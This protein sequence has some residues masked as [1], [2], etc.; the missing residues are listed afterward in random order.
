MGINLRKYFSRFGRTHHFISRVLETNIPV[1]YGQHLFYRD[2]IHSIKKAK[3]DEQEKNPR[4][5][6]NYEL[7]NKNI[8]KG[9]LAAKDKTSLH[10]INNNT[11]LVKVIN[12]S[13]YHALADD[14][15]E[16]IFALTF[17][18]DAEVIL[19]ISNVVDILN[20]PHMNFFEYFL[21][22]LVEEK[23]KYQLIDS[24]KYDVMYINNFAIV[25]FPF[26]SGGRLDLLDSFMARKG[27]E[28]SEPFRKLFISRKFQG[29]KPDME[30]AKNFSYHNDTRID[31]HDVLEKIFTDLGFEV[32]DTELLTDFNDQIK[33]FKE[34]KIVVS[35]TSSGIT[36]AIF[37]NNGST[38]VE[39]V[40]PLI[41]QS[42]LT[43]SSYFDEIGVDPKD[44]DMDLNLVQEVH[45]FYHNLAFFKEHLYVSIP[46]YTREAEKIKEFI[47]SH[48]SLK[49]LLSD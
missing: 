14:L 7:H 15:A 48:P 27:S 41:T 20:E 49:A 9:Y 2:G 47:E 8:V 24:S 17:Y 12:A 32:V 36:N 13:F 21:D 22:R 1:G 3:T 28:V 38:L 4:K 30:D 18:P 33:V 16:V 35:L 6:G 26:H 11:K 46:N 45:M 31:D 29:Y 19:E 34:A 40:T 10:V 37:M 25:D 23:V 39:I 43:S 42:P 44:Y 5:G